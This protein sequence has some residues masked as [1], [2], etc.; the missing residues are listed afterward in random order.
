MPIQEES[1]KINKSQSLNKST[2]VGEL[3]YN[4]ERYNFI[5]IEIAPQNYLTILYKPSVKII[6]NIQWASHGEW[7]PQKYGFCR[8]RHTYH[9][10][11]DSGKKLSSKTIESGN[12]LDS[13]LIKDTFS[14]KVDFANYL[15]TPLEEDIKSFTVIALLKSLSSSAENTIA[16][17]F[18]SNSDKGQSLTLEV[19]DQKIMATIKQ[20]FK[21]KLS[22]KVETYMLS[23]RTL[24]IPKPAYRTFLN[25]FKDIVTNDML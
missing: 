12:I 3:L 7:Q 9:F 11:V 2:I 14:G 4:Q 22:L 5:E 13:S 24:N 16:I 1:L 6:D 23:C 19:Y 25:P 8:L 21:D 17:I 15:L 20:I 18:S 10:L